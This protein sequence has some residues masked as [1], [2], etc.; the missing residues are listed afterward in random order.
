[1]VEPC[2]D[3]QTLDPFM[4][5]D[6]TN[7]DPW[8]DNYA[9]RAAGLSV[10]EVRALFAVASRPE[11]VSL[12]GGMPAVSAL[13]QDLVVTAMNRVMRD[14][15]SIALQYGSGQGVPRLREHILEVM[16]MEG[17]RGSVDDVV[18][19]TGSQQALDL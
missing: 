9:D 1:M 18:V 4:T 6:G 13:P 12:A 14:E 15:G 2:P 16:A 19:T 7:L 5:T 11:V 8:Y 17:I 3:Q 10:S